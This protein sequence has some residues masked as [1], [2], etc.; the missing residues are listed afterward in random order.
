MGQRLPPTTKNCCLAVRDK[1]RLG[2]PPIKGLLKPDVLD[3]FSVSNTVQRNYA[4]VVTL[5]IDGTYK[6][7]LVQ[8]YMAMKSN[9]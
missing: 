7:E 9:A 1:E 6:V 8:K 2:S 5:H 3:H 4:K